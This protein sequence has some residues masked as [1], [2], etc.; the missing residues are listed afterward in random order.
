[1]RGKGMP[2]VDGYGRGDLHVQILPEIPEKLNSKQKKLLTE[3]REL[4]ESKQ[5]PQAQRFREEAEKM[6]ER[7]AKVN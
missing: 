2:H 3:F 6:Y 4:A 1:L 5:Y 7:K